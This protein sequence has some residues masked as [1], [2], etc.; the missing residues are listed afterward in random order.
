MHANRDQFSL[1]ETQESEETMT[2]NYS[3]ASSIGRFPSF[4]FSPHS[5]TSLST[6]SVLSKSGRGSRKVAILVAVLEVDGPDTI[7]IKNGAEAGKQISMLKMI[8]GDEEGNVSKLVAWRD[9]ADVW[10]GNTAY[11]AVKR[12]DICYIESMSIS[13]IIHK[14]D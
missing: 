1:Q 7:T 2:Y 12:G 13:P 5:L 8:L 3:D 14:A 4:N 6:L 10:G 11:P 9:I